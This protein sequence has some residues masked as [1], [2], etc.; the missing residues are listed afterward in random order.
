VRADLDALVAIETA[1]FGGP[2]ALARAWIEPVLAASG[3][4]H[5]L[6]EEADEAVA[7]ATVVA[8]DGWAGRAAMVTG[9]AA[10]P[11]AEDTTEPVVARVVAEAFA[12]GATLVHAHGFG[13]EGELWDRLGASEVPAFEVRLV[14]DRAGRTALSE[15][16]PA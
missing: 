14:R 8:S 12:A 9:V 5:W 3:F 13:D 2:P 10:L 11:G 1:A 15:G 16:P 6:V 4:T 7:V